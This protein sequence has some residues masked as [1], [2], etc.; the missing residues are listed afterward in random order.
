MY[1]RTDKD[2]KPTTQPAHVAV[3]DVYNNTFENWCVD[4]KGTDKDCASN[5][6]TGCAPQDP[7]GLLAKYKARKVDNTVRTLNQYIKSPLF[8]ENFLY[9]V[10]G[11]KT[12]IYLALESDRDLVLYVEDNTKAIQL[13]PDTSVLRTATFTDDLIEGNLSIESDT[14][15]TVLTEDN[16]NT[17][18]VNK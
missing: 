18:H 14:T 11:E 9:Q 8:S 10:I 16:N 3:K 4:F 13:E 2:C 7:D 5:G 17:V 12:N 1:V 15:S 6:K